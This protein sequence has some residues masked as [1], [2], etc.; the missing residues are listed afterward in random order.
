M[1]LSAENLTYSYGVRTLFEDVSFNVEEGDKYGIIGVNGTGKSTLLRMIATRDAGEKGKLTIP[2]N[3]VMEYL[4]Q[5][6]QEQIKKRI[7]RNRSS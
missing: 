4:P 6:V 7:S 5:E 1:I 3:V 2:G